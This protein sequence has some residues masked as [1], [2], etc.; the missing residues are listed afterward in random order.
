MGS[1][2]VPVSLGLA[3]LLSGCSVYMATQGEHNPD[4]TAVDE[5]V[6]RARVEAALGQPITR[7][8]GEEGERIDTYYY[9]IGNEPSAGRAAGHAA[10][11]VLTLGLWEL[12]GTPIEAVQGEKYEA[13]V[14]YDDEDRVA[15]YRI[16]KLN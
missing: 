9:E 11:D 15:D 12:A 3:F 4:V 6:K 16:R 14:T 13:V 1:P 8:R 7:Q 2:L 5:G 10:L